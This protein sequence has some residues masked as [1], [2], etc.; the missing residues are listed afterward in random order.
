ML[1]PWAF[2]LILMGYFGISLSY[3]IYLK[4]KLMIDVVALAALYGIRVVAGGAATGVALSH[5]LVG[6]CFFIFLSL[7]MMKRATEII[8]LPET[9]VGNVSGRGYR[10]GDLPVILTLTAATGYVS[11]LVLALY[12]YSP[13]VNTFYRHPDLLWGI[14]V[15]LVYW[16]GRAFV[17]TGRGEMRSDPVIFAATDRISLLAGVLVV[18]VFMIAS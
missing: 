1:L 12:M 4:R 14:C 7:A 17:L 9:N 16:L 15:I 2:L 8:A 10:R 18:A 11:V 3:S 13:E 6:F 5:W